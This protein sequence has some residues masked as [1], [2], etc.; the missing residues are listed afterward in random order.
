MRYLSHSIIAFPWNV[1]FFPVSFFSGVDHPV[2]PG[3]ICGTGEVATADQYIG[4]L[5]L[6]I[7]E[8]YYAGIPASITLAQGLL[9]SGCGNSAV[10]KATIISASSARTTGWATP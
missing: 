2:Q 5:P 4:N 7:Q 6:A 3:C 8:M 9:E 10:V 1:S